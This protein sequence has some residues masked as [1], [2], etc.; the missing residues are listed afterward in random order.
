[1]KI[2]EDGE[3]GS[4]MKS[5]IDLADIVFDASVDPNT[6]DMLS[7]VRLCP[8]EKRMSVALLHSKV[9][10]GRDLAGKMAGREKSAIY[11]TG[12]SLKTLTLFGISEDDVV[13]WLKA[14]LTETMKAAVIEKIIVDGESGV[15]VAAMKVAADLGMPTDGFS[16]K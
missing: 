14:V 13:G 16:R 12:N 4:A 6:F 10:V 7:L 1:M 15:G 8:D 5:N 11:I 9:S 3:L 2:I